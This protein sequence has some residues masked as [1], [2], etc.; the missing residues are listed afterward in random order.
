MKPHQNSCVLRLLAGAS[1]LPPTLLVFLLLLLLLLL[2]LPLLLPLLLLLPLVLVLV[3]LL[4][5]SSPLGKESAPT[6]NAWLAPRRD[7]LLQIHV[8]TCVMTVM[9][10]G[11]PSLHANA[12]VYELCRPCLGT[13]S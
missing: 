3:L 4:L 6:E 10:L 5:L 11:S 1:S 2:L 9:Y 13:C 12:T 8:N 7:N